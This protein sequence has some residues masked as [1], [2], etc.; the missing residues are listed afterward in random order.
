MI[1]VLTPTYN[2]AYT[3]TRLFESLMQQN[4]T[5]EWLIVDDGSTDETRSLIES[6]KLNTAFAIR[7]IHQPNSGKHIALNTGALAAH[8]EYCLIVDSDDALIPDAL[9]VI[10]AQI[11]QYPSHIGWCFRRA[12]F[13]GR[14]IGNTSDMPQTIVMHPMQA[15]HYFM[16]DLAYLFQTQALRD[17]PFPYIEG[18]R[19]VPELLIWNRIADQGSIYY[20]PHITPYLCEYLPDGYSAGFKKN[21]RRNP[22]GFALYY[23]DRLRRERKPIEQLKALIRLIQ[24]YMYRW[25]R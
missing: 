22:K 16:G 8:G 13:N 19:F 25:L 23:A 4:C 20:F 1:T 17:N 7:Y 9:E 2:R 6:F 18:E 14:I 12:Y 15:N 3:L 10:E 24:C 5:F 21:L 11:A